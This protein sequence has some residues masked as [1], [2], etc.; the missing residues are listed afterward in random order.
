MTELHDQYF[1]VNPFTPD[2]AKSKSD[3]V[4]QN[5]YS[6]VSNS[7]KTHSIY[8]QL[9]RKFIPYNAAVDAGCMQTV[10]LKFSRECCN[11]SP[12]SSP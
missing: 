8:V 9:S 1:D 6:I 3:K 10:Y 4:F 12:L 2:S 7:R 5:V 11:T